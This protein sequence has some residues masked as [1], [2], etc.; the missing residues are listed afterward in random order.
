MAFALKLRKSTKKILRVVEKCPDIPVPC[1]LY[2]FMPMSQSM[3]REVFWDWMLEK[4]DVYEWII[5]RKFPQEYYPTQIRKDWSILTMHLV[6]TDCRTKCTASYMNPL[7]PLSQHSIR[8]VIFSL[9]TPRGRL[10]AHGTVFVYK[11]QTITTVDDLWAG[12]SMSRSG[13]DQARVI[14]LDGP[15]FDSPNTGRRNLFLDVLPSLQ[16][17]QD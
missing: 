6:F 2:N 8:K 4:S 7:S 5:P 10:L 12:Y 13:G 15:Y 17:L 14:Q 3:L 9:S 16:S 1:Q 11:E